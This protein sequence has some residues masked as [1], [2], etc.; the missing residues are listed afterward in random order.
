M[1]KVKV[2][3][4]DGDVV[5]QLDST[6]LPEGLELVVEEEDDIDYDWDDTY[7]CGCCTCCGCMCGLEDDMY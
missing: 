2:I 6:L 4:M 1:T 3:N 5:F 7:P